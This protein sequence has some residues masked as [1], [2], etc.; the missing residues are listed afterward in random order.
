MKADIC[1]LSPIPAVSEREAY[2]C[3]ARLLHLDCQSPYGR[4]LFAERGY[5]RR[6]IPVR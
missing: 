4:A 1:T 2:R 5:F 6:Q 3:H